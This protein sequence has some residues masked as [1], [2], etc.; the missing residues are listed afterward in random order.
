MK[1]LHIEESKGNK[2]FGAIGELLD[3]LFVH[4]LYLDD[5]ELA[6]LVHFRELFFFLGFL[7]LDGAVVLDTSLYM[8]LNVAYQQHI[9]I[10]IIFFSVDQLEHV[11][12]VFFQLLTRFEFQ[13]GR[14]EVIYIAFAFIADVHADKRNPTE[15]N[16]HGALEVERK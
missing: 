1:T 3:A 2:K 9:G 14:K 8:F 7:D 12:Q 16:D 4:S 15:P 5:Q 11:H 6:I 10:F 13:V